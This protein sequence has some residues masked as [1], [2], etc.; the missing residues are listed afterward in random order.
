MNLNFHINNIIDSYKINQKKKLDT[1]PSLTDISIFSDYLIDLISLGRC[2]K[3]P[4]LYF[5]I[6]DIVSKKVK[7]MYKILS[8]QLFLAYRKLGSVDHRKINE[9]LNAFF[10]FIPVLKEQVLAD[11]AWAY[12]N[13]PAALNVD[14]IILSYPL[15]T[16]LSI[17][18]A[19]NFLYKREIPFIP[20]MMSETAH[21]RTGID[22]HPGANIDSPFFIDHGTGVVIGQTTIIGKYCKIYQG[23]TLG[24]LNITK[25]PKKRHP[26]LEDG[27]TVYA[28]AAILGDIIIGKDSVIG[29]NVRLH[30]SVEQRSLVKATNFEHSI[31][32]LK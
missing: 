12:E 20:R 29:S 14:E 11:C 19:A 13:D 21:Q 7:E 25:G 10:Q 24:A 15:V 26:T 16:A 3:N 17:Y 2:P 18:R 9:D 8:K 27:V 31:K 32:L 4:N 23:V 22:I 28:N 1:F 6:E 5:T 30:E